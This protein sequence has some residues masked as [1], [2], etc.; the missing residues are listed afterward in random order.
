[1]SG[2]LLKVFPKV[3]TWEPSLDDGL[4]VF[5]PLNGSGLDGLEVLEPHQHWEG[6]RI[7]YLVAQV[8][9][10]SDTSKVGP[11]CN[12]VGSVKL[13][14]ELGLTFRQKVC[15]LDRVP[16]VG[17]DDVGHLGAVS[18]IHEVGNGVHPSMLGVFTNKILEAGQVITWLEG[19]LVSGSPEIVAFLVGC[20]DVDR[21]QLVGRGV[22]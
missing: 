2:Q 21:A 12:V 16:G 10:E 7:S 14:V 11:G 4:Q 15:Q 22:L 5:K 19:D 13:V 17:L 6:G 20:R 8:S 9:V 3:L 18:S 1:M